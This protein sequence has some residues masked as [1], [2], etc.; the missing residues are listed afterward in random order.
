MGHVT[1]VNMGLRIANL[2]VVGAFILACLFS[3]AKAPAAPIYLP[4]DEFTLPPLLNKL[5]TLVGAPDEGL[6]VTDLNKKKRRA[7]RGEWLR[8]GD[9]FD[10]PAR[11]SIEVIQK[12]NFKWIGG[13]VL[14]GK[15][16][17][18]SYAKD[19]LVYHLDL[20]RGWVRIWIKPESDTP[21]VR[22]HTAH[23]DFEASQ[24]EFWL[25][26]RPAQ[27]EIYM[28]SGDLTR[29]GNDLPLSHRSYAIFEGAASVPRYIAKDWDANAIEVKISGSYPSLGRMIRDADCE[30]RSG[31]SAHIYAEYRK[32]GWKKADPQEK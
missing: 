19:D 6:N 17:R 21:K 14:Q 18:S 25:S 23:G 8:Y 27:T 26:T 3:G 30:W 2:S 1:L 20:D 22:I 28:I 7:L 12:E 16:G 29:L 24:A 31:R 32:K 13:G 5:E 10:L 9:Q 4:E 11:L 15:F